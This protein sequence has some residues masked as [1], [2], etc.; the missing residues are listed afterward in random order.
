MQVLYGI[1]IEVH[2][3]EVVALLGPNGA[4]KTT[5]LR[6]I[7]GQIRPLAGTIA[8]DGRSVGGL[9]HERVVIPSVVLSSGKSVAKLRAGQV[10]VLDG[11]SESVDALLHHIYEV[12][13][14]LAATGLS[15]AP[16][17]QI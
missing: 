12:Q 15:A 14:N 3:G 7:A 9:A 11:R 5:L 17:T 4:G 2:R 10:V 1:D 16:L 8:L 13:Q 6:T